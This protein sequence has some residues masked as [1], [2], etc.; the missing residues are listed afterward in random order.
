LAEDPGG[1]S[2]LQKDEVI[3]PAIDLVEKKVGRRI[4]R[5]D[6]ELELACKAHQLEPLVGAL[7]GTCEVHILR[8]AL[9]GQPDGHQRP[10]EQHPVAFE[11]IPG[12][13]EE[14]FDPP[15]VEERRQGALG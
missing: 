10:A 2:L 9:G 7:S 1:T 11:A 12:R 4:D 3:T 5:F 15:L 13:G 14:A 8:P 6:R